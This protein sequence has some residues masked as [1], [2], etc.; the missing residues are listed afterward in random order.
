MGDDLA[1]DFVTGNDR[2]LSAIELT[3]DDVQVG[4]A[5]PARAHPDEELVGRGARQCDVRVFERAAACRQHHRFHRFAF[6]GRA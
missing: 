6:A 5:Y 3:V 2:E 4:A 1:D